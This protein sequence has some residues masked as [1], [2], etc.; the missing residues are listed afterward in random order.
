MNK[1]GEMEGKKAGEW[2]GKRQGKI[3]VVCSQDTFQYKH[4]D[5]DILASILAL[6][7]ADDNGTLSNNKTEKALPSLSQ[8]FVLRGKN[9]RVDKLSITKFSYYLYLRNERLLKSKKKNKSKVLH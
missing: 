4:Q 6:V 8:S 7:A 9:G 3:G 2:R 5:A 1:A